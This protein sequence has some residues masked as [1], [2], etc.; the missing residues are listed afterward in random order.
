MPLR[1]NLKIRMLPI[2]RPAKLLGFDTVGVQFEKLNSR[3][4]LFC[5]GRA[6]FEGLISLILH[7][8]R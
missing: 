6:S 7:Y 8:A 1:N 2:A 4:R 5:M 3:Y